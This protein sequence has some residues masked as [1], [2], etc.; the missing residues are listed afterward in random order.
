MRCKQKEKTMQKEDRQIQTSSKRRRPLSLL[1]GVGLLVAIALFVVYNVT[2]LASQHIQNAAKTAMQTPKGTWERVLDGYSVMSI[3]AAPNN[4]T[5]LYACAFPVQ[6]TTPT[7]SSQPGSGIPA[8]NYI[9]LHSTDGG[10]HWQEVTHLNGG[11]QIAVNPTNSDDIYTTALSAHRASNGQV[12]DVLKHSTD[13]GRSWSDI[14]PALLSNGTQV[15]TV[16]HVQQLSMVGGLLFGTQQFPAQSIQPQGRNLPPSV[17]TRLSVTRLVESSDGGHTWTVI[18]NNRGNSG[19]GERDYIVSP[20]HPQVVYEL[21]GTQWPGYL[22]PAMPPNNTLYGG[23]LTLYKT[24]DGG[25]TWTKLGENLPLNSKLQIATNNPDIVYVGSTVGVMP[26]KGYDTGQNIIVQPVFSLRMSTNGGATW[27][28][29][30]TPEGISFVQ[31]W[32]VNADGQVYASTSPAHH[33]QPNATSGTTTV[34]SATAQI[35]GAASNVNSGPSAGSVTAIQR[36]NPTN[37]TWSVVTQTPQDSG[38]LAVTPNASLHTVSLWILSS[39]NGK[40]TLYRQ[41]TV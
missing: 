26:L 5:V 27:R 3:V 15:A 16:W 1:I 21:A 36:Y 40:P 11:C 28:T 7:A 14:A 8:I 30:K 9:L 10:T 17:V 34:P 6:S 4:S 31:N 25:K 13:G 24:D 22:R 12:P 38:L 33:V 2:T 19:Q 18:D 41:E 20:T 23:N 32:F 39:N 37:N 29:L 35:G